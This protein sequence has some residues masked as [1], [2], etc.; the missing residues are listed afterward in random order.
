MIKVQAGH[1]ARLPAHSSFTLND[2]P[3]P[4]HV[5]VIIP[6]HASLR[7]HQRKEEK[8]LAWILTA[9]FLRFNQQSHKTYVLFSARCPYRSDMRSSDLTTEQ[10]RALRNKIQ[11]TLGYL[12]RLKK[13]MARRGFPPDDGLLIEV[14]R[15]EDAMHRLHVQTIYLAKGETILGPLSRQAEK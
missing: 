9:S 6:P 10:A 2:L 4:E 5:T 8:S 13:W 7:P 14:C 15:A 3:Q 1:L 11:P 12:S